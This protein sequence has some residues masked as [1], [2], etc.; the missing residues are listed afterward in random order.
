VTTAINTA[1]V[2]GAPTDEIHARRDEITRAGKRREDELG[3]LRT[4]IGPIAARIA[5]R[6]REA[7][8]AER[9]A[10]A[11][12]RHKAAVAALTATRDAYADGC[13]EA[14]DA[15]LAAAAELAG[16]YDALRDAQA[17]LDAACAEV[18]QPTVDHVEVLLRGW[19]GTD[20]PRFGLR[21]AYHP[22]MPAP[23][24]H[25]QLASAL[26]DYAARFGG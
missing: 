12:A 26:G 6:E 8:E 22:D 24:L 18:G 13:V 17:E 25:G 23:R 7:V 10:A 4:L 9:L 16:R 3:H 1:V 11:Q 14:R 5:Q 20:D 21:N 2:D 15:V 19:A